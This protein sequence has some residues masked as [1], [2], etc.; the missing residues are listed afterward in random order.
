MLSVFQKIKKRYNLWVP[1]PTYMM[2][3]S[4]GI[5]TTYTFSGNDSK[6]HFVFD[7]S[8]YLAK[9]KKKPK[10][11]KVF[12]DENNS[13]LR[14]S[15][16][17]FINYDLSEL[18]IHTN[19]MYFKNAKVFFEKCNVERLHHLGI[20][21]SQLHFSKLP[22]KNK[23]NFSLRG[24]L[25]FGASVTFDGG[26]FSMVSLANDGIFAGEISL[27]NA[28]ID[29]ILILGDVDK[30]T[31]Y[32]TNS[33]FKRAPAVSIQNWSLQVELEKN[34]FTDHCRESESK[35]RKIKSLFSANSDNSQA[36][37]FFSH[38]LQCRVSSLSW[39]KNFPEK[40]IGIFYGGINRYGR[41]IAL[42]F[43][44]L[45][46][47]SVLFAYFDYEVLFNKKE[48]FLHYFGY[49]FFGPI[50]IIT[51]KFKTS[52]DSVGM[53][54][55]QLLSGFAISLSYFFLIFGVRRKFKLN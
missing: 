15:N 53:S 3:L 49:H 12:I 29:N 33:I 21:T 17:K 26:R 11:S 13:K 10:L 37:T 7:G 28:V 30:I 4:Q 43:F 23:I 20:V 41:S 39:F 1:A 18:F 25:N 31:L 14:L 50:S 38:E 19:I 42:P 16:M 44:W 45:L 54:Y 5:N 51:G 22:K 40:I 32:I 24:N 55:Y 48:G 6:K 27:R 46:A 52:F 36:N 35:Y 8:A 9:N 47:L 2:S 34:T